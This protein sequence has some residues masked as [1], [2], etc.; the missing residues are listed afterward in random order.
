MNVVPIVRDHSHSSAT[1][2]AMQ[3]AQLRAGP[4]GFPVHVL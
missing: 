2:R 4:W 1:R 3:D